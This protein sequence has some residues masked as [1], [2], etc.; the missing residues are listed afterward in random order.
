[1]YQAPDPSE[2]GGRLRLFGLDT[3]IETPEWVDRTLSGIG[4]GMVGAARGVEQAFRD[5]VPGESDRE[6][7]LDEEVERAA[8][9]DRPLMNTVAG[10]AG[11]IVGN[12]AAYAPAGL[13]PGANTYLGSALVGS[14]IGAMQPVSDSGDRLANAMMGA[15][16]G[17]AGRAIT[18]GLSRVLSPKTR[19]EVVALRNEGVTP[20]PGQ[21]LGGAPQRV[22]DGL[23]SVPVVGDFIR[24]SQRRAVEQFNRAALNRIVSPLGREVSK[25][26][27]EGIEEAGQIVDEAYGSILPRLTAR[28]DAQ[29]GDELASIARASQELA[30]PQQ[31]RL[32][33]IIRNKVVNRLGNQAEVGGD[34]LKEIDSELGR[35]MRGFKKSQDIDV[36]DLGD[37]MSGL[38]QL[39]RDLIKRNNPQFSDDLAAADRAYANLL[40]VENAAGRAGSKEGVF[41][42]AALRGAVRQ[43]DP[44]LRRRRYSRGGALMQDLAESGE[45]VL[46]RTV[47][48]S[49]TPFRI[50][51]MLGMG[52]AAYIDPMLAG[53]AAGLSGAYTAP[54]QSAIARALM[55]RPQSVRALGR[56]VE[57]LNPYAAALASPAVAG[58]ER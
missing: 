5:V 54:M 21:I 25:I 15:G 39:F 12:V 19:P 44:S 3:G 14:G 52:G 30:E 4:G 51:N 9:R 24:G 17:A 34:V 57:R 22:E 41:S 11:N 58:Q 7:Q 43:M 33:E 20:T 55:S 13:I 29:F 28:P 16:G 10:T 2:G 50:V 53:G 1:M 38:K 48:D 26:G 27:R 45:E 46:G 35:L 23:T 47:P 40:R 8:E 36:R 6:I 31:K 32:M 42:P 56:G 18:G 49:G 37:A